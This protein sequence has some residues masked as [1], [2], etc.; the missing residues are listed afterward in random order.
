MTGWRL[1]GFH[2]L[3]AYAF[4]EGK[5]HG[6]IV[7]NYGLHQARRISLEAPVSHPARSYGGSPVRGRERTTKQRPR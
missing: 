7:F 2:Q 1:K 6:L 4:E 5:G 3:D